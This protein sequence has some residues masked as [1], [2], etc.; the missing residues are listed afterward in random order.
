MAASGM[1]IVIV[2]DIPCLYNGVVENEGGGG[3]EEE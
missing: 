2:I 3:G 1:A